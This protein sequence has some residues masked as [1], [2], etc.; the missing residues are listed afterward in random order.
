[1]PQKARLLLVEDNLEYGLKISS[2]LRDYEVH[3]ATSADEARSKLKNVHPDLVLMDIDLGEGQTEDG[4]Q[5]SMTFRDQLEQEVPVVFLTGKATSTDRMTGYNLGAEDYIEKPV[6][7]M[8]LQVRVRNVLQRRRSMSPSLQS[9]KGDLRLE[10]IT[11]KAFVL[12]AGQESEIDLTQM[13]FNLLACLLKN[14]EKILSRQ[15]LLE[16]I[17]GRKLNVTDRTVDVHVSSLRKKLKPS[18]AAIES[19]F[20][21][22]YRLT[23]KEISS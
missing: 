22:G 10:M 20:G 4:F 8:E 21:V 16:Q 17:W 19:V 11:R 9:V 6:D 14:R 7:E 23:E 13:E 15:T 12:D 1:M 2:F 5:L 18:S 3:H